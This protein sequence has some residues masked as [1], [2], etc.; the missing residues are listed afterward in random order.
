[1]LMESFRL[2]F[3][4][5]LALQQLENLQLSFV[6]E[7]SKP[8]KS[9]LLLGTIASIAFIFLPRNEIL[10]LL[11]LSYFTASIKYRR[12][13]N[14]ASDSLSFII[15]TCYLLSTLVP[16]LSSLVLG[17]VCAQVVA[18]YFIAGL[19]KLKFPGWR[20]GQALLDFL[21]L[22]KYASSPSARSL[23]L[24]K[25]RLS[26]LA[27]WTVI[28]F[29][30]SFPLAFFNPLLLKIYLLIGALFHL[31]NF[32]IFGLN[33]FFWLW[34]STYPLLYHYSFILENFLHK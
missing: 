6:F 33:R 13:I 11:Y 32:F 27:S 34:F 20:S 5:F 23:L 7:D 8:R 4:F 3:F 28:L 17:Y 26:F 15:L 29:E 18:S 2:L 24:A 9:L 30:L 10:I 22:K 25:P 31:G 12:N 16:S 21:E 14:G 1:M 19:V